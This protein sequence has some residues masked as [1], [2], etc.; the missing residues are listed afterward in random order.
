[1]NEE[2]TIGNRRSIGNRRFEIDQRFSI[3][4]SSFIN[5]RSSLID[6]RD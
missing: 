3:A 1:M 6:A 4:D 5:Y 2:S